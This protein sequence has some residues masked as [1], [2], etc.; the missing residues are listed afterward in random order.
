[1]RS[2]PLVNENSSQDERGK[3]RRLF[4]LQY[5]LPYCS[6]SESILPVPH[7]F[8]NE[9]ATNIEVFIGSLWNPTPWPNLIIIFGMQ[10]WDSGQ[11]QHLWQR[12]HIW[13]AFQ[14]ALGITKVLAG[15]GTRG[16]GGRAEEGGRGGPWR[17]P[18][19]TP[20]PPFPSLGR[21]AGSPG[22]PSLESAGRPCWGFLGL[23][24]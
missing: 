4:L 16:R 21:L 7:G 13:K 6:E 5:C 1:M 17:G 19:G 15:L 18:P 10:N 11:A 14:S 12:R 9:A 23:E 3:A 24:S 20:N 22:L 2:S 8:M